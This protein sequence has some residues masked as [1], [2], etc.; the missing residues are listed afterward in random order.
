MSHEDEEFCDYC[1]QK[2]ILNNSRI[3]DEMVKLNLNKTPWVLI[4]RLVNADMSYEDEG[5]SDYCDQKDS[6]IF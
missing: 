2:Y 4:V 3:K 1:Y 5:L 6:N